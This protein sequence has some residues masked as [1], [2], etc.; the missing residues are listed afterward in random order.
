M[1]L[2]YCTETPTGLMALKRAVLLMYTETPTVVMR[3]VF[4]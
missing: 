2:S 4:N 3:A 1:E